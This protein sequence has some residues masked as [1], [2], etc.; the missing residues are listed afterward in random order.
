MAERWKPVVGWHSY[1]DVSDQGRLRRALDSAPA[2]RTRP[3]RV[4][5]PSPDTGGYLTV[6]LCCDGVRHTRKVHALVAAT[7]LGPRPA[8]LTIDHVDG[9]KLNNAPSNLEYVSL[10]ENQARATKM[11][12][13]A[14]KLDEHKVRFIRGSIRRGWSQRAIADALGVGRVTVSHVYTGKTWAHIEGAV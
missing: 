1:Y 7:F 13:Y 2:R 6:R 11:G 5:K 9:D 3:G 4:L 8:G 12:L 10:R 14:Q